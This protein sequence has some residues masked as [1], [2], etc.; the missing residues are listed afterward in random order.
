LPDARAPTYSEVSV[1]EAVAPPSR[2][3]VE[4]LR[5][6]LAFA[7]SHTLGSALAIAVGL[8]LAA[9]GGWIAYLG[10][11]AILSL[12]FVH[13]FVLLHEAGHHTLFASRRV[14]RLVGHLAGF[15][16]L[17]PFHAWQRIHARHH[18]YTGWQDLD[19]TTAALVPRAIR[20]WERAVVNLAW[21]T[22]LPLFS[23]VYRLQNYWNLPRIAPFLGDDAARRA[24]RINVVVLLST[25]ALLVAWVGVG[26]LLLV[27]PALLASLV[28][29]DVLLLSQHTH[30]P[31]RLSGGAAVRAFR[32]LEQA[33]FTRSLRLPRAL[34]TLVM[35]F[36]AHELHHMYPS[37]P[38]YRLSRIA[39]RAPNEVDWIAWTRAAKRLSGVDFLF[40]NRNDTG[41]PV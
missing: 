28:I 33:Q 12:A 32:P 30:L 4:H 39:Y 35:H 38:G 31:Q 29:E 19:A 23:I 14:N 20:P 10:A 37:V 15:V 9:G 24:V 36:D 7:A 26:A 11:Q 2:A 34:S 17:I 1:S 41:A 6:G 16:A 3:A 25:Y 18:R 5:P 40:R 27:G 21:R 22:W 13:A 8:T